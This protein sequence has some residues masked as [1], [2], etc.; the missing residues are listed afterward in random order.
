MSSQQN[1]KIYVGLSGGVDSSVAAALLQKD[2]HDVTGVYLK[3][4]S[5]D[6]EDLMH[7]CPW[8][9]DVRY[10]E[11]TAKHLGI[12]FAVWDVSKEY[13]EHVVDYFIAEHRLGRTPNPDIMCNREIKFGIFLQ[14][15]RKEG[16]DLI[17][18]GHYVRKHNAPQPPLNLRGGVP[19]LKI[20]GG[21][22]GLWCAVDH[23]KDQS[24]FLY[25]LTQNQ[26]RYA[27]FPVGDYSKP[28]VRKMAE[29]WGL[30]TAKRKDSQGICFLGKIPVKEFLKLRIPEHEGQLVT[31]SGKVVG[32]HEGTEFYTI[33]QRHGIG[34]KGGGTSY[35][36]AGKN[37][38]KNHVVVAETND[39]PELHRQEIVV[40]DV[41]WIAGVAPVLPLTCMA[42]IR[43]RQPLQAACIT[44]SHSPL[45]KGEKEG[46]IVT[47]VKPQ[48]AV[49]PGQACVLYQGDMMLGG[50]AIED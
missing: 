8:E 5:P 36:V 48:R 27:L 30:P 9:E 17:A 7:G 18:T 35:Y 11:A 12:P 6:L 46:V 2:G 23:N 50:G 47:F 14:R 15:S 26:L 10:A 28:E 49:T 44:P 39:A 31:P 16:A 3:V 24:Y 34:Y 42:R 45:H 33:G 38:E 13:F 21:E 40:N 4:W 20:R 1:K 19:P 43:Y 41:R 32:K 25:S 29:E 22:E 37:L